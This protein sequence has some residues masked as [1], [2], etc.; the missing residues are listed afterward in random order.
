MHR[1]NIQLRNVSA[2]EMHRAIIHY[3]NLSA[4]EIVFRQEDELEG[5]YQW[6]HVPTH[7]HHQMQTT[8]C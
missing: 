1:A 2:D 6:N 8:L 4:D 5:Q 7:W 3:R